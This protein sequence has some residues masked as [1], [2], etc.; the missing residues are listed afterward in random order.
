M[1]RKLVEYAE[2]AKAAQ[3]LKDSGKKPTIV[4]VRELLDSKG[5]YTTISTYLKRWAEENT[6]EQSPP[7][8]ELP[9]AIIDDGNVFL[10]RLY[11]AAQTAASERLQHERELMNRKELELK[12]EL[13]QAIEMANNDAERADLL[14]EQLENLKIQYAEANAAL[15]QSDKALSLKTAE[16]EHALT[17]CARL[18]GRVAEL[19]TKLGDKSESLI[20]YQN[21]LEQAESEKRSMSQKLA[22][23][24]GELASQKGKNIEQAEKL[25][26]AH[27]QG[28]SL[29]EQLETSHSQLTDLQ[30]ELAAAKAQGNASESERSKLEVKL[31]DA[32]KEIRTLDQKSGVMTGQLQERDNHSKQL[33]A[34]ISRLEQ[35][36]AEANKPLHREEGEQKKGD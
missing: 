8:V 16:L 20:R 19:E 11:L 33:E 31:S 3:A 29:K 4:S 12:D 24:E 28:A 2:V 26:A 25:R 36:L 27:E 7:E 13:E 23:T 18:Q 9:Q 6:L 5:S 32:Q 34:T 21:Q 10:K 1:A 15:T 30:S 22:D 17:D 35:E 14:E